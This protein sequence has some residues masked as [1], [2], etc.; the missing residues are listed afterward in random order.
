M[1][2]HTSNPQP[3]AVEKKNKQP[4]DQVKSNLEGNNPNKVKSTISTKSKGN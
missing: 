2:H 3:Q 1:V 4:A